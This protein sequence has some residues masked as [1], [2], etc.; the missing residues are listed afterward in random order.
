MR[1]TDTR[2]NAAERYTLQ[3]MVTTTLLDLSAKQLREAA[4]LRQ[5]IESL[6]E[7]LA[8]ILAASR[9]ETPPAQRGAAERLGGEWA[10]PARS[11]TH[12]AK[13]SK[14][15]KARWAKAKAAGNKSL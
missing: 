2:Q 1:S 15:L 3:H 7:R 11:A 13:L 14:A 4:K 10:K 8:N 9:K 12:R 6:E 5:Q